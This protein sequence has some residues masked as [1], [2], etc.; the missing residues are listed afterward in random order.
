MCKNRR[1]AE[2]RRAVIVK[3]KTIVLHNC[4]C[5]D[6]TVTLVVKIW[7]MND[8]LKRDY[9]FSHVSFHEIGGIG[10]RGFS[11]FFTIVSNSGIF[12]NIFTGTTSLVFEWFKEKK[13]LTRK[14]MARLKC[15]LG[16]LA[17]REERTS[18]EREKNGFFTVARIPYIETYITRV[19]HACASYFSRCHRRATTV[20]PVSERPGN[21][22]DNVTKLA[23]KSAGTHTQRRFQWKRDFAARKT[24]VESI[25]NDVYLKWA[26]RGVAIWEHLLYSLWNLFFTVYISVF[27]LEQRRV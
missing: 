18:R 21:V 24:P 19:L 22:Y 4:R 11:L 5:T 2:R 9:F 26:G 17:V 8:F 16:G 15:T 13:I 23:A 1:I 14:S 12:L 25:H 6:L 27:F 7:K 10:K 20:N 3:Q